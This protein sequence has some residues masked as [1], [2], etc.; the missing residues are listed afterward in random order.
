MII[1]LLAATLLSL[2]VVFFVIACGVL[3]VKWK[4]EE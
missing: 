2:L 4:V 3:E 1:G